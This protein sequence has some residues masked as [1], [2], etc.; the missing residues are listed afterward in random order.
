MSTSLLYHAFG[1][2]GYHYRRTDYQGGE[3]LESWW[4]LCTQERTRASLSQTHPEYRTPPCHRSPVVAPVGP[5]G[6]APDQ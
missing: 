6:R 4:N 2:R 1:I 5:P 3:R